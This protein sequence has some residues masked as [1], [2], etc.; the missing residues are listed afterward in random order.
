MSTEILSGMALLSS[1]KVILATS[2]PDHPHDVH[3]VTSLRKEA[4]RSKQRLVDRCA[5]EVSDIINP[6]DDI[7]PRDVDVLLIDV[8]ERELRTD[9]AREF[10]TEFLATA[11]P[12][13][14]PLWPITG[15]VYGRYFRVMVELIVKRRNMARRVFFLLDTDSPFTFLSPSTLQALG[16]ND[17]LPESFQASVHGQQMTLYCSP[18]TSH[19]SDI[20][21][22]GSDFLSREQCQ[23]CVDYR[24]LTAEIV[25]TT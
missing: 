22:L 1:R 6:S 14:T 2:N 15:F 23:L 7:S 10:S 5:K 24:L 16:F 12:A 13:A 3:R 18:Q 11:D 25:H 4:K 20:N 8:G 21:M 9:I 19:F 17:S